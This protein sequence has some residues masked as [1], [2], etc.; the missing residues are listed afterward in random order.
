MEVRG[1]EQAKS[2]L[3]MIPYLADFYETRGEGLGGAERA[4]GAVQGAI[5]GGGAKEVAH[6]CVEEEVRWHSPKGCADGDGEGVAP[7]GLIG[8]VAHSFWEVDGIEMHGGCLLRE[9]RSVIVAAMV[10]ECK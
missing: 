4:N 8:H 7:I 9:R 3:A 10:G 6:C 1:H 2:G 5:Y